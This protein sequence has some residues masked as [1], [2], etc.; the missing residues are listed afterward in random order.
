MVRSKKIFVIIC[1]TI[2]MAFTIFAVKNLKTPS[3]ITTGSG[4][5]VADVPQ[6]VSGLTV[7]LMQ[8]GMGDRKVQEGD[9]IL[10]RYEGKLA[11]GEVFATNMSQMEPL[12]VFIGKGENIEGWEKGLVG[13][14]KNEKRKL[15]VEPKLGYG[16]VGKVGVPPDSTL[17]YE[18][19]LLEIVE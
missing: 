3:L 13:M 6:N 16:S 8:Y 4:D 12:G 7:E 14:R 2:S 17:T 19:H 18:I 11:N 5:V 15:I 10:I 9:Y 1:M